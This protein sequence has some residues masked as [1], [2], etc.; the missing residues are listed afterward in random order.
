MITRII[1][2][3]VYT[4]SGIRKDATIIV[5]GTRILEISDGNIEIEGAATIDAG[6]LRVVPGGIDMHI[7]GGGGRDYME[8]TEDAFREAMEAHVKHGT[9]AILPTLAAGPFQMYE[10]AVTVAGKLMS[11]EGTPMLGLHLEGPY[12]N[13]CKVGAIS[14]DY[15][16]DPLPSEYEKLLE[17]NDT[18]RRW[19]AA[20]ELPGISEFGACLRKHGVLGSV[21]HTLAEYPDVRKACDAGF[22][23]ATHFYNAMS[24]AH[25]VREYKHEGT[26]ESIYA[27]P[28][29]D[30]EII[31]DGK[32]V[33][34]VI[35]KMVYMFKG[36]EHTALITDAL[37]CSAS[38]SGKAYD[39]RVVIEDGVCK[40]SDRSALAG[41]IA[42][43]D[44]LV[45][46]MAEKVGVPFA[47]VVRMTSETPARILGV[48]D[49]KGTL[50]K[51]KD[52][53]IVFYDDA[54]NLR[55]VMQKGRIA[56]PL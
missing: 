41:S 51:G 45:R 54:L 25:N 33:P 9:T 40:L 47:D 2:G 15:V 21:A 46:T 8:A 28:E 26:I 34:P 39:P 32:H 13:P 24:G 52:A 53:D 30:V 44:V 5:E 27:I 22:T 37:A 36:A 4:P 48:L 50:E 14:P 43:M 19:D 11:E 31:A 12:L 17:M 3:Y 10:D 7:H 42:T 18:I 23:L 20:P 35:L 29:M 55:F 49:R 6:G 38:E 16:K 56:R 1:G